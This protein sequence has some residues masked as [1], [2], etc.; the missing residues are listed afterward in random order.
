MSRTIKCVLKWPFSACFDEPSGFKGSES[1]VWTGCSL[2]SA[3]SNKCRKS[4]S[5]SSELT[6]GS[7]IQPDVNISRHKSYRR[8]QCVTS[9]FELPLQSACCLNRQINFPTFYSGSFLL[10]L[11]SLPNN[12]WFEC[13]R[14]G[15]AKV[16]WTIPTPTLWFLRTNPQVSGVFF[17]D[18]ISIFQGDLRGLGSI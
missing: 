4:S 15:E 16:T 9:F 7:Q 17:W 18:I 12:N 2:H 5:K 1:K 14:K 13:S 10:Y 6:V 8:V 11:I 3:P